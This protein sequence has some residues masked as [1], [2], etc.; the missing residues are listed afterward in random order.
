MVIGRLLVRVNVKQLRGVCKHDQNND[1]VYVKCEM[2]VQLFM[3]IVECVAE[4][5]IGY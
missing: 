4:I 3:N 2:K 5:K 1:V